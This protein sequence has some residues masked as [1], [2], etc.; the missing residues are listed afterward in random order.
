MLHALLSWPN[1]SQAEFVRFA[2]CGTLA[3]SLFATSC[4]RAKFF[5]I[6]QRYAAIRGRTSLD[7][8]TSGFYTN[9]FG[10]VSVASWP[11][12]WIPLV[13]GRPTLTAFQYTSLVRCHITELALVAA[14]TATSGCEAAFALGAS[15]LLLLLVLGQRMAQMQG[16]VS[17]HKDVLA[18]WCLAALFIAECQGKP[19]DAVAA[20]HILMAAGYGI[21][22]VTKF[23]LPK[24]QR[25]G[26]FSWTDGKTLQCILLERAVLFDNKLAC[27]LACQPG[28]CIVG[29]VATL[30]FEN[31]WILLPLM[32][33][34]L[35][36]VLLVTGLLFHLSCTV[37]LGINFLPFWL[38]CYACLIP[39][40]TSSEQLELASPLGN[41]CLAV[42]C[43]FWIGVIW[44]YVVLVGSRKVPEGKLWPLGVQLAWLLVVDST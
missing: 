37:L 21:P 5:E 19:Q 11:L 38:P 28:L 9:T 39:H 31:L 33:D 27:L 1:T 13:N 25:K 7:R 44:F 40:A 17:G 30:C 20:M 32:P 16:L 23:L 22:G 2:F 35:A 26:W 42:L 24:L 34:Q 18:V 36:L 14:A 12:S 4:D 43:L 6:R 15:M 3:L 29:S 8:P 10:E 41:G